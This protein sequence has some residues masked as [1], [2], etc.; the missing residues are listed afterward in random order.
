MVVDIFVNLLIKINYYILI[1]CVKDLK[2]IGLIIVCFLNSNIFQNDMLI[3]RCKVLGYTKYI[4]KIVYHRQKSMRCYECKYAADSI[5]CTYS[6]F[7]TYMGCLE[8]GNG[9]CCIYQ[10]E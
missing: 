3:K 10:P 8:L 7:C 2:N 4:R 6:G 1:N 5:C 9:K